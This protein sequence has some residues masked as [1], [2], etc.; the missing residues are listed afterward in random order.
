MCVDQHNAGMGS[1]YRSQHELVFVFKHDSI[2]VWLQHHFCSVLQDRHPDRV[3]V[4]ST[5]GLPKLYRYICGPPNSRSRRVPMLISF[6]I[7]PAAAG[8][9]DIATTLAATRVFLLLLSR[10]YLYLEALST[11]RAPK[12][13]CFGHLS[14]LHSNLARELPPQQDGNILRY[15]FMLLPER[16]TRTMRRRKSNAG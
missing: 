16:C 10:Q 13:G 15:L 3:P 14:V 1:F 8:A 7:E 9:T 6:H 11:I 12:A 2:D 4:N 5:E